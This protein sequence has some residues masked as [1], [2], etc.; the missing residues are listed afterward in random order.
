MVDLHPAFTVVH[1]RNAQG[2]TN[3]LEAIYVLA[4]LK[5]F[6]MARSVDL[7][8]WGEAE[9]NIEAR[10][11]RHDAE[12]SIRIKL[13]PKGKVVHIDGKRALSLQETFGH[14]Q[15]V[16]FS[17]EDLAISK[18]GSSGRRTFLDRAIFNIVPA[19]YE[20]Q[21]QYDKALKSRNALIRGASGR[22]PDR[23]MMAVFDQQ[24]A[25][26]GARVM[27]RRAE[28]TEGFRE[29]ARAVHDDLVGAS[30]PLGLRY[31]PSLESSDPTDERAT[32]ERFL[33]ELSARLGRDVRRGSTGVGPHLDELALELD[34]K[35]VRM[36]AS[37]GQH[38]TIVL[39]LK[40]AEIG[41]I[42]AELGVRPVLLLDDVSSELD[43]GRNAQLMEFLGAS[44]GQVVITTT[45]PRHIALRGDA[46][47]LHVDA[48]ALHSEDT[49]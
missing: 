23:A 43:R 44:R 25:T 30:H 3:L 24:V 15:V 49:P 40:I 22:A 48:G 21:R 19:Y 14:V 12:R 47:H 17:P 41:K 39:A 33:G 31:E 16:L 10:I 34:G 29:R 13:H 20:E 36:H 11:E 7:I 4:T 46:A 9:A 28:F 18:A 2:K 5:S 42:E 45:D 35:L 6:R 27:R 1:G 26:T 32:A 37:Q 38:R 8:R